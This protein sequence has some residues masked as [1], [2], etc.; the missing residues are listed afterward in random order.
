MINDLLNIIVKINSHPEWPKNAKIRSAYVELGKLVHKDTRFFYTILNKLLSDKES[1]RYSDDEI[2]QMVNSDSNFDYAV[3]CRNAANMLLFILKNVGIDAQLRRSYIPDIYDSE[4]KTIEIYHYFVTAVGDDDKMY[5]LSLNPDLPHIQIGRKTSHFANR[6]PYMITIQEED[7]NG[8]K[9]PKVIQNYEGEK[10]PCSHLTYNEIYELDKIIGYD[11]NYLYGDDNPYYTDYF[12]RLIEE[13]FQKKD[14]YILELAYETDFFCDVCCLANGVGEE[15]IFSIDTSVNNEIKN[16]HEEPIFNDSLFNIPKERWDVIQGY[17]LVTVLQFY[18]GKYNLVFDMDK[19]FEMYEN[20]QYDLISDSFKRILIDKVGMDN[21]V[22]KEHRLLDP[23]KKIDKLRD[24]LRVIDLIKTE[25][26]PN[27]F[28]KISDDFFKYLNLVS[29]TFVEDNILPN[30]KDALS[31]DYIAHKIY[32][33]LSKI[34]DVGHKTDF[35]N[36]GLAEQITIIK[37][38]FKIILPEVTASAETVPLY[39]PLKSSIENRLF[40]TVILEKNVPSH[41][42]YFIMVKKLI[43]DNSSANGWKSMVYD[44]KNNTIKPILPTEILDNYYVIK[45]DDLKLLIEEIDK[46]VLTSSTKK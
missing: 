11:F 7:E 8:N 40:S 1:L 42:F 13:S 2:E 27:K 24:L 31:T 10:L 43:G 29:L 36:L 34:L 45:D 17:V 46:P 32:K 44:F 37:E 3:I 23:I 15:D 25:T 26:D 33:T 5:F 41:A 22:N 38:L 21:L 39:N 28:R 18:K 30:K 16:K 9:V 14:N 6:V 35:N 20:S 4:T 12:F 19:Y